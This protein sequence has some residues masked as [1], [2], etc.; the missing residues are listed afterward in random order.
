MTSPPF[1]RFGVTRSQP[2]DG[3]AVLAL[4]GELD[5]GDTEELDRVL[6][7]EF[8]DGSRAVLLDLSRL[9]FV[10]SSGINTLV[11]G[12]K[13]A[14]REGKDFWVTS[15][16]AN[17][18][19]VFEILRLADVVNIAESAR[20]G[21][22]ADRLTE[23]VSTGRGAR[24]GAVHTP[25]VA[26]RPQPVRLGLRRQAPLAV[27]VAVAA[28][29]AV[30]AL[31]AWGQYRDGRDT[32]VKELRARVV[33]ASTVFNTYFAGQIATLDGIAAS[34]TFRQ[35]DD[36]RKAAYLRRVAPPGNK[37]FTGGLQ[38]VDAH[39]RR[40]SSVRS[41]LGTPIGVADRSYFQSVRTTGKP[42][43]SEGL[44]GR[45]IRQR[46]V[47]IA[48]PTHDP[49]G[50]LNG[51]LTGAL[52][53]KPTPTSKS[54]IDLGYEGLNILDRD[55][56]SLLAGFARPR[57]ASILER[58]RRSPQGATTDTRGL[59]GAGGHVVVW[60]SSPIAGWTTVI[61]RP[62]SELFA[63]ARRIL[64]LEIV[65][66]G[67]LTL[68]VLSVLGWMLRRAR[69]HARRQ[70]H[71]LEREHEIAS[72]LQRSLLPRE[73]PSIEGLEVAWRYRAAGA[74][75]E[76]GGDWYDVV[77]TDDGLVHAIV[78]DVAGRGLDAA[79]LMGQ[80]RSTF[81]AYAYEHSSPAEI[82]RRMLRVMPGDAMATAV[83]F[84]LDPQGGELRYASAGHL[85]LLLL[86]PAGHLVT[87]LADGGAPLLGAT[88]GATLH[89]HT[90]RLPV[91]GVVVAYTD[92]LVERR[93]RGINDGIELL[94]ATLAASPSPDADGI[95]EQILGDVGGGSGGDGDDIA[96]LVIRLDRA[97]VAGTP[98]ALSADPC[99]GE[100]C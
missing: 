93:T 10:D 25:A 74:G 55:Q 30:S 75:I 40:V 98:A 61:D 43:V 3:V 100:R 11:L 90:V 49:R 99:T 28:L 35:G 45:R 78:G 44:V 76:V 7:A 8:A 24:P 69:S 38:W 2:S 57:N 47:V 72:R 1:E 41:G 12:S 95:A 60:A 13:L 9:A 62:R 17:V 66:I 14:A 54:A 36:L 82:L 48:V 91:N 33:L 59:D 56:R 71:D 83:C 31:L 22:A 81:H 39:E 34:P 32:A 50:A 67:G 70:L 6:R 15:P 65:L 94:E 29:V 80:L 96:L 79:T 26:N 37:L 53:I 85:P 5:F 58:F 88:A 92:G 73:L 46:L 51:V 21:L 63:R 97:P 16:T 4:Q 19:Q 84:T 27:L 64:I 18:R 52:L 23:V 86:D 89:D 68:V 87:R 77:E 42:F 20:D